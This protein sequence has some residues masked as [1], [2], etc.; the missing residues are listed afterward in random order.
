MAWA[1][2]ASDRSIV[3][4][5]QISVTG[6]GCGCLCAGCGADLEAVNADKPPEHFLRPRAMRKS[7]RHHAG[8]QRGDC[9]R[10]ST[11][12]AI[13]KTMLDSKRLVLPS[14]TVSGGFVGVSGRRHEGAASSDAGVDA[15]E[16]VLWS[17]EISAM[18]VMADGRKVHLVLRTDVA[19][20]PRGEG[21]DAVLVITADDP[22]VAGWSHDEILAKAQLSEGWCR[23]DRHWEDEALGVRAEAAARDK[24]LQ[25]MD[26]LPEQGTDGATP[27]DEARYAT[28]EFLES[29]TPAQRGE[30]LLHL[31][32]KRLLASLAMLE[33]GSMQFPVSFAP[34]DGSRPLQGVATMP[35]LRLRISRA[36]LEQRLGTIVPDVLCDV[37]DV[38]GELQPSELIVEVAVTHFVGPEKLLKIQAMD[39]PC[40][41][42]DAKRLGATTELTLD[43]LEFLLRRPPR[44]AV[45]WLHHPYVR[46]KVELARQELKLQ[47]AA[48][49]AQIAAATARR[50]EAERLEAQREAARAQHRRQLRSLASRVQVM[51]RRSLLR[52]YF[53]AVTRQRPV[54]DAFGWDDESYG[55]YRSGFVRHKLESW[56]SNI[57]QDVLVA[58]G[59]IRNAGDADASGSTRAG[60][61][62]LMDRALSVDRHRMRPYLFLML[63]AI[64]IHW[65]GDVDDVQ[66]SSVRRIAHAVKASIDAGESIYA[67]EPEFDEPL[68][69]LFPELREALKIGVPGT[70][71]YA[72]DLAEELGATRERQRAERAEAA[73]RE[74][75]ERAVSQAEAIEVA[76]TPAKPR[77]RTRGGGVPFEKWSMYNVAR[78]LPGGEALLIRQAYEAREANQAVA[79]FV[80]AKGL[81]SEQRVRDLLAVLNKVYL[82]S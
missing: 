19:I 76:L 50:Q 2:R 54:F 79:D 9:L 20:D 40:L 33:V 25:F 37:E 47:F 71:G 61:V 26:A 28:P 51:D 22:E 57:L 59:S 5:S 44:G 52:E 65:A 48:Q 67:R 46:D 34:P 29:L 21:A 75:E 38:S 69:I 73:A 68:R 18:L 66:R 60:I 35:G 14:R 56:S 8:T 17:D 82:L 53:E 64:K 32:L 13:F 78:D 77:Q 1:L 72:N 7:F 23:W 74:A 58:L 16:G 55:I 70:K 41:E 31:H 15:V 10:K 4:I 12:A 45:R 80:R 63:K 42:F 11:R 43:R 30:T 6:L 81:T 62:T 24:A 39:L 49:L 36:R 3:H 27:E